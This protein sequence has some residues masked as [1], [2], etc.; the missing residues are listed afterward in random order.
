MHSFFIRFR[1]MLLRIARDG[2]GGGG[3]VLA[4]ATGWSGFALCLSCVFVFLHA[5]S[6][7]FFFWLLREELC[8]IFEPTFNLFDSVE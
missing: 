3:D 2:G 6:Q 5:F 1:F 8:G 7:F 4:F